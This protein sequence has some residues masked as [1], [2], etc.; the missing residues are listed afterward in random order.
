MRGGRIG[1]SA[2]LVGA[3][4]LTGLLAACDS[5][6]SG[7]EGAV[8][9]ATFNTHLARGEPGKLIAELE[10][11]SAQLDAIV[12]VIAANDPDILVIQ[13]LDFDP[14]GLSV[15]LF[16]AALARGGVAYG[17]SFTAPVNTGL[18]TGFDLDGDGKAFGPADAQGW[19]LFE[20]QFGMAVLSR[21]PIRKRAVRTFQKLRWL[22]MPDALMPQDFYPRDA[23]PL[24][25]L[26][27]KSH[28]DV[29]VELVDGK[30]INLLVSHPTPPVFDGPE[31]RNGRRNHDEIAFWSA[32]LDGAEWIVDDGGTR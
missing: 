17:F 5:E 11:G 31:D 21:Y 25:R 2:L 9:I 14:E 16:K 3:L 22:D 13:E 18:A 7:R 30:I 20:G 24:L 19:G 28:W 27:S 12:K 1:F 32:Y 15:E 23:M 29:P 8:R 10:L 6:P 26:S 4:L